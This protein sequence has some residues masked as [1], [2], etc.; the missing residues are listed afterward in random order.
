M[1]SDDATRSTIYTEIQT[2]T[3]EL[4]PRLIEIRRHL[5]THPE[6]SGQEIQTAACRPADCM[7]A[8]AWGRWA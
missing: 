6:L 1:R 5:H 3:Q 4:A 2:L 7:S 8:R